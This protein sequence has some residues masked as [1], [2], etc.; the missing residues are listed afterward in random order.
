MVTNI[1]AVPNIFWLVSYPKSGNTWCRIFLA[2][3]MRD[4]K[5]PVCIN[6]IGDLPM[7]SDRCWIDN[8]I[9]WD[10]SELTV[11]EIVDFRKE[12]FRFFNS[13]VTDT[14]WIKA[15][16]SYPERMQ[17]SFFLDEITAG[18]IYIVRNPLDIAPSLAHHLGIGIDQAI[19]HME[20]ESYILSHSEGKYKRQLP[21]VLRSW[22]G[23]VNSW[24]N[25]Y[26]GRLLLIRYEDLHRDPLDSFARIIRFLGLELDLQQ[27]AQA[28][29]YSSFAFLQQQESTEGF[30]EKFY[31]SKNFFRCGK[32]EQWHSSLTLKQ[33]QHIRQYHGRIMKQ[34]G[35]LPE[36]T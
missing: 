16:E 2:N 10:S 31:R 9:G 5:V 36:I 17:D 13:C 32:A 3:Y 27:V 26:G 35:Y 33:V 4:E 30:N 15:H 14:Q 29:T 8:Y 28:L 21:Q 6:E 20:D 25:G 24:L 1:G 12:A 7:A 18:I 19:S 11:D 23:H 34:L 22:S